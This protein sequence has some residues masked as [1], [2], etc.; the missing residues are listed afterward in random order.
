MRFQSTD[1]DLSGDDNE[2]SHTELVAPVGVDL[3]YATLVKTLSQAFVVVVIEVDAAIRTTSG[4]VNFAFLLAQSEVHEV[5]A[6]KSHHACSEWS[7]F[8]YCHGIMVSND[9]TEQ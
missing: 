7:L 9:V 2:V 3:R 1:K 8:V 5:V 4:V 6:C